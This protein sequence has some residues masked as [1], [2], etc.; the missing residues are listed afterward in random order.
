MGQLIVEVYAE[1]ARLVRV[2]RLTRDL[3]RQDQEDIAHE[4]VA[5]YLGAFP[6]GESPRNTAAWLEIAVRNEASDFLRQRRRRQE[7][8]VPPAQDDRDG[9]VEEVLGRLR[10]PLTPSLFPVRADL[11]ERV[12]GLLPPEQ[13]EVLRLRFVED[14]DAATVATQLGVGRAAVDQRV[15]R[16]KRMLREA[17]HTRPGLAAELRRMHP[18]LY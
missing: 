10:A 18:R 6:A 4:A 7:R 2:H 3:S 14:L 13:A 17:L 9:D 1:A 12:L 16:A 11:L 8:E 15:A 5:N